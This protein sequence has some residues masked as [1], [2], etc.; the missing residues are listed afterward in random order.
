MVGVGKC[1]VADFA[2]IQHDNCLIQLILTID[3]VML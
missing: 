2:D 1:Y 3:S